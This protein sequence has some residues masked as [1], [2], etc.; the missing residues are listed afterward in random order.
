M[1]KRNTWALNLGIFILVSFLSLGAAEII[2]RFFFCPMD[3]LVPELEVDEVYRYRIRAG[4]TGRDSNGFRN[5][6][7]PQSV[8]IVTIGDSQTEGFLVPHRDA[9]PAVLRG[10][11]GKSVYNMAL[12]GYGPAQYY[13]LFTAKALKMHPK[14][15]IFCFYL[16]ND[17][18]DA[19]NHVYETPV[20]SGFRDPKFQKKD[21]FQEFDFTYKVQGRFLGA[22]RDW[23]AC[24]SVVYRLMTARLKDLAQWEQIRAHAQDK[25][26]SAIQDAPG[27]YL[28]TVSCSHFLITSNVQ[29]PRILEGL[30]LT[31]LFAGKINDECRR[32]GIDC[33]FM[34]FT[35]KPY[36]F[37][38][39][40]QKN[41]QPEVCRTAIGNEKI[42]LNRLKGFFERNR[43]AYL[44]VGEALREHAS[45]KESIFPKDEEDH[46]NQKGNRILAEEVADFLK[47]H[48]HI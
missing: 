24:H 32:K 38:S 26:F 6:S 3:I 15:I 27:H 12:G 16:G 9:W 48:G 8:D 42:I 43:M 36:T 35:S 39:F 33:Y 30:R 18:M 46:L 25:G 5:S 17:L 10:L 21:I 4:S 19:F 11:T 28:T 13:Q 45:R 37:E 2:V 44:D 22:F 29:D 14:I 20:L 41:D 31:E 7:V 47:K 1:P 23:L 40:L 34:I